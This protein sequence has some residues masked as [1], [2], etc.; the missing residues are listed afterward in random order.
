M[1]GADIEARLD[2]SWMYTYWV[3]NVSAGKLKAVSAV[4]LAMYRYCP[5]KT[6]IGALSHVKAAL[7]STSN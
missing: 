4:L 3:T 1:L 6:S 2:C 5:M 7:V